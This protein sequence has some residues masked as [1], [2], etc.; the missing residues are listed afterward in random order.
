MGY[1]TFDKTQ[2]IN[3]E[4]SLK[5]E[6]I[7]SNRAGSYANTTIINC[8]TRKYHGL[9]VCPL[10]DIDGGHHVLLSALDATI[11]QHNQEFHLG[12]HKYP[13]QYN[14]L[15]HKYV[16]DFHANPIPTLIYR[17]GGVVMKKEILLVEEEEC[18]F[19]RY[20]LLEAHSPTKL[21]LHPFLAFRNIHSLSKAN[22]DINTKFQNINNGIRMKLYHGYPY[23]YMQTSKKP[24]VFS[25][26]DWYYN[27]EYPEEQ[28]RG[29]EYLE[30]LFVPGF[31]EVSIKKDESI[32][33]SASLKEVT[34]QSLNKRFDQEIAKRVP[35]SSFEM[36]LQN[37]AQQFIVR[38]EGKVKILSGF[39]WF[40]QSWARDTFISLPGLTLA[41]G[42]IQT[43]KDVLDTM[44]KELKGCLFP[45]ADNGVD[46]EY[47][48]VDAPLWYFWA[49]QQYVGFT[50]KYEE[51]WSEYGKK[52][53]KILEGYREGTI[54]NI[55][56]RANSLIFSGVPGKSLT[57]MDA[58]SNGRPVTPRIGYDVEVNALWYN[59]ILFSLELADIAGDKKFISQW[60]QMIDKV[61]KSFVDTFWDEQKGY[62]AD[63]VD[64][65]FKDW[66][67]RPNQIFAAS[68][69]FSPLNEEQKK[70]VLDI[71]QRDLLTPRGL[72]TLSPRNPNY[73]GE[74]IGNQESRDLA[75]HQGTAWPWLIGHFC[76]AYLRIHKQTGVS[77]V[78]KLYL[79]FE[80]ETAKYGIG[81][82]SEI[83][84]GNPPHEA[85]GSVSQAWSVAE[86]LRIRSMLDRIGGL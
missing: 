28:Q 21:R 72:R 25:A 33:F 58:I 22:M 75:Y 43:C 83:Y 77:L 24:E 63:Y 51:A 57:W 4:Y 50:G 49:I 60:Q 7:R 48:S 31:F 44:S 52:M 17:V 59:A 74:Y 71:V 76:E 61:K 38:K 32:V 13:G 10:D 42:D 78:K 66:S 34:T 35:R 5:K 67:V 6:L 27:L 62:L 79:G 39:P 84:D 40:V 3:L 29:Y 56:M 14:P 19:I 80:E 46:S 37:S 81:T 30:D 11:I 26:P 2:L 47:N 54:Y 16:R 9:L 73:K 68:L 82:I 18:V 53:V 23:L 85:R 69:P 8:N 41:V 55:G 70:Q 36:C 45:N 20:T 65:E 64:G 12:I 15:G 1:I 86:L